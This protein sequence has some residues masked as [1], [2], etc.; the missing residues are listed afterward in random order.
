MFLQ[1]SGEPYKSVSGILMLRDIRNSFLDIPVMYLEDALMGFKEWP[2]KTFYLK[3]PH[4][5]SVSIDEVYSEYI[6]RKNP[7]IWNK[8]WF[9]I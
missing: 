2:K 9:C 6:F 1:Y 8:V 3:V 4:L 7:Q 5:E